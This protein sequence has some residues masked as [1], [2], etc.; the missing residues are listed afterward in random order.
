MVMSKKLPV[1]IS[2]IEHSFH[3]MNDV[4]MEIAMIY[5]RQHN[6]MQ[7]FEVGCKLCRAEIHTIQAIGNNEGMNVTELAELFGVSKPT[8]S[9]RLKK[10]IRYKL[11]NKRYKEG[12]NKEVLLTLTDKGWKAYRNHE[13]QHKEIFKLYKKHFGDKSEDFIMSFSEEL[14]SFLEFLKKTRNNTIYFQ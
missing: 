5:S 10:L 4:I 7:D 9:E 12:N 3:K 6:K 11:V 1:K 2:D 13:K 14:E 8:I